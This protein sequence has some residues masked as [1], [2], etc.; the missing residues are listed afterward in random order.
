MRQDVARGLHFVQTKTLPRATIALRLF[1]LDNTSHQ[2]ND[3]DMIYV[4][5]SK[6]T[7]QPTNQTKRTSPIQ[8]TTQDERETNPQ[9][10]RQQQKLGVYIHTRSKTS[11]NTSKYKNRIQ[12]RSRVHIDKKRAGDKNKRVKLVLSNPL[13]N[14]LSSL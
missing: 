6:E 11:I 9:R 13:S 14:E 12:K 2:I 10:T 5:P 8:K 3:V 4:P 1:C 7:N